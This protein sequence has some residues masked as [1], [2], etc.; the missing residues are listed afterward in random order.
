MP[1]VAQF[2]RKHQFTTLWL[3]SLLVTFLSTSFRTEPHNTVAVR[4]LGEPSRSTSIG[5][6][7]RN[8]VIYVPLNDLAR[9]FKLDTHA[10]Q[11]ARKFEIHTDRYVITSTAGSPYVTVT[12]EKQTTNVVQLPV[13]A[14]ARDDGF[15][16]PVEYFI[17]IL[18]FALTEN[19]VFDRAT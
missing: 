18:D 11:E 15:W 5:T 2:L 13:P 6:S 14:T 16:A 19:V 7:Q 10:D 17:P 8:G 12:D 3:F 1:A 4:F 9:I